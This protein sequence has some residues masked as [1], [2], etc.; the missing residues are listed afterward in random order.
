MPEAAIHEDRQLFTSKNHIGPHSYL[1]EVYPQIASIAVPGA[2]QRSAERHLG[3]GVTSPVRL[4]ISASPG[5]QR[6]WVHPPGMRS[7][8]AL[9]VGLSHLL[10]HTTGFGTSI[11][12]GVS[13]EP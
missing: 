13:A 7:R 1:A 6:G 4:H 5:V 11:V 2:V 9:L 8:A 10:Q 3:S 12:T